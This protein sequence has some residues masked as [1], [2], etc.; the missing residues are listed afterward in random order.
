MCIAVSSIVLLCVLTDYDR[1]SKLNRI[2]CILILFNIGITASDIVAYFMEI[3]TEPYAYYAVRLANF[4][5]YA[6]GALILAAMTF[7]I[8]AYMETK[9]KIPR[10]IKDIVLSLCAL[11]MI[12]TIVSQFTGIYYYIDEN[13]IYHRGDVFWLSQVLPMV[14]MVFNM[15]IVMYYRKVFERKFLFF[16]LAYMILPM[17]AVCLALF[18]QGITFINIASTLS[19]L[20]LYLSVQV[21]HTYNMITRLKLMDNQLALQGVNYKML[22]THMDEVKKA[23]HDLRHH[24]SVF[25]AFLE[26]GE[27]ENLAD[28]IREYKAALPNDSIIAYC[29]NYAINSVLLYYTS[30]ARNEGIKIDVQTEIPEKLNITDTD[31]CIIFGNCVENAIDACRRVED[32][33]FIKIKSMIIG[34]MLAIIIDNS[35]DGK[36]TKKGDSFLSRKENGGGIGVSSVKTIVRKYNGETRFEAKGKVFQASIMLQIKPD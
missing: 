11:S 8:I 14:G 36:I 33:K 17:T 5:H 29:Q 19:V 7:Y 12:L 16:F 10:I 20:V 1:K 28:Y 21:D 3:N 34:D 27:E 25:Q 30:L 35:F 6:F 22:Q 2:F 13:N 24:L 18:V 9:I 15:V 4:F 32:E 31:L 26:T 23:R